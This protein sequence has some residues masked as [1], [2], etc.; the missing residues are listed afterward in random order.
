[1]THKG[2]A[3]IFAPFLLAGIGLILLLAFISDGVR[4]V[5][6]AASTGY[7]VTQVSGGGTIAGKI[8]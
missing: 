1:M 3:I 6:A 4:A 2:Q 7:T 8:L 5:S